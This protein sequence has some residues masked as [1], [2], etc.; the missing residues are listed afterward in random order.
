M[1]KSSELIHSLS[2]SNAGSFRSSRPSFFDNRNTSSSFL[3]TISNT[4]SP[5][6]IF[7]L[8][9]YHQARPQLAVA[10]RFTSSQC[11]PGEKQPTSGHT[12]H[13][14]WLR[15]GLPSKPTR[16]AA[17]RPHKS[18]NPM[19]ASKADA[20][21][22]AEVATRRTPLTD[23]DDED[24]FLYSDKGLDRHSGPRISM[25][26]LLK[27]FHTHP[28]R[29]GLALALSSAT[30]SSL[31]SA[32]F[33]TRSMSILPVPQRSPRSHNA[34][35]STRT[36]R[37][38]RCAAPRSSTAPRAP[39]LLGRVRAGGSLLLAGDD[40]PYWEAVDLWYGGTG[41]Y[42]W[43]SPEAV[44]TT[45]GAQS[46]PSKSVRP[47]TRTSARHGPVVEQ[48]LLPGCLLQISARLPGSHT[49]PGLWPGM[50]TQG[51]LGRPGYGATNE[52]MWPYSYQGCDTGA[53]PNQTWVNG[54]G[55]PKALDA[56]GLFS[57]SYNNELSWLPGMRFTL[58]RLP[59]HRTP[60]VPTA[61]LLAPHP[62]SISSKPR[63]TWPTA[64]ARRRSPSNGAF[65][66]DYYYGNSTA[67][68]DI[69]IW[70]ARTRL[71][72]Y[73]GGAIQEA[74]SALSAVPDVALREHRRRAIRYLR[75]RVCAGLERGRR[76]L[77]NVVHGRPPYLD[78]QRPGHRPP[79]LSSMSAS[80]SSPPNPCSSS[81][82][83][84]SPSRSRYPILPSSSSRRTCTSTTSAST[85]A[86]VSPTGRLRPRQPPHLRVHREQ[87]G[88]LLR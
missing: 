59:G 77:G 64:T 52:G 88:H 35:S 82:T 9:P 17:A 79:C 29:H 72:D 21:T 28:P 51:N 19:P 38:R 3:T 78:A 26:G 54:T 70:D 12:T 50:W 30:R 11:L 61:A 41:D 57:R 8:V 62:S 15:L 23:E 5:S 1:S 42:E 81:S 65:D 27:R 76:R 46:S 36:H 58:V 47:T 55:P 33:S 13:P 31:S 73:K 45:G 69:R 25:R 18:T 85:S 68:G 71:N 80:A 43:Y 83:S 60:R 14:A 84:P 53:L 44:N 22:A 34:V 56:N 7:S 87:Q 48:S 6:L 37:R 24:D 39:R 10:S 66:V 4:A 40:D 32:R 20:P 49:I 74:V 63:S 16:A 67:A 86:T 2:L 75:R